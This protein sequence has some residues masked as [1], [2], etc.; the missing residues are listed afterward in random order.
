MRKSFARDLLPRKIRAFGTRALGFV[1]QNGR[2]L[3]GIQAGCRVQADDIVGNLELRLL[4]R[5]AIDADPAVFNVL[6]GFAARAADQR[7]KA[8]GKT[9]GFSHGRRRGVSKL[10]FYAA[11]IEATLT[12]QLGEPAVRRHPLE[13]NGM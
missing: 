2:G 3:H 9:N 7:R 8:L 12:R 5:A 13:F 10:P 6:L 11:G 4:D 1:Q